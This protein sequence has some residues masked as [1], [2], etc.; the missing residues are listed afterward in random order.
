MTKGKA[1]KQKIQNGGNKLQQ[2][3]K[4]DR[5]DC[6]GEDLTLVA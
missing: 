3:D 5:S 6:G 1:K 4:N 2:K